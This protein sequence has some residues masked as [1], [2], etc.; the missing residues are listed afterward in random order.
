MILEG[1]AERRKTQLE[2]A[3][4]EEDDDEEEESSAEEEDV[5]EAVGSAEQF[6][7]RGLY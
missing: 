6:K 5:D 1:E 7:L 3:Q 4:G 2:E